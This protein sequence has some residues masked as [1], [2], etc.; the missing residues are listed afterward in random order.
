MSDQPQ[1]ISYTGEPLKIGD[2][3]V[4]AALQR[5]QVVWRVRGSTLAPIEPDIEVVKSYSTKFDYWKEGA[6][7]WEEAS[8]LIKIDPSWTYQ[9]IRFHLA[10]IGVEWDEQ[11]D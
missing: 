11:Y 5:Y 7:S 8:N 1:W 9:Q 2:T 10:I 4:D 6:I 3:V